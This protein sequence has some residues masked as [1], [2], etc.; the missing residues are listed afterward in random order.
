M[1]T[2]TGG[3][4]LDIVS[5]ELEKQEE[6]INGEVFRANSSREGS[7]KSVSDIFAESPGPTL[8]PPAPEEISAAPEVTPP[9]QPSTPPVPAP[10]P[11][12]IS[13]TPIVNS[14]PALRSS[15]QPTQSVQNKT[16]S[17]DDFITPKA[18][19]SRRQTRKKV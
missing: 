11:L 12:A 7:I 13:S 9:A 3:E 6:D 4:T 15:S 10:A 19:P 14:S 8:S 16:D 5:K 18:G 17:D 1:G 2:L